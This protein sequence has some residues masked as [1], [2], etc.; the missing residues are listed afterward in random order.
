MDR[1][2]STSHT[3]VGRLLTSPRQLVLRKLLALL[4]LCAVLPASSRGDG[5]PAQP[6]AT[7]ELDLA[8]AAEEGGD[9]RLVAALRE[10]L[11]RQTAA[12]AARSAPHARAPEALIAPLARLACGRDPALAPEAAMALVRLSARLTPSELGAREVLQSDLRAAREALACVEL[13]PLPRADVV[14]A[15]AQLAATLDGLL[16]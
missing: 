8:R 6:S 2:A 1:Q 14:V 11:V 13:K 9:A 12:W 4:A 5:P 7:D 10:P 3:H 15:L 16:R